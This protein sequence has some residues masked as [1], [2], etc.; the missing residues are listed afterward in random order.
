MNN[1][2]TYSGKVTI[3]IKNTKITTHNKGTVNLGKAIVKALAGYS[4]QSEIPCLLDFQQYV[5]NEWATLL[6]KKTPFTG[7]TYQ[8]FT[9]EESKKSDGCIGKLI[10]HTSIL[11]ENKNSSG[12]ISNPCR[13]CMY[14]SNTDN[15]PNPNSSLGLLA[16]VDN[17]NDTNIDYTNTEDNNITTI[18]GIYNK[19]E[20]GTQ[21][22][23]EWELSFYNK[24]EETNNGK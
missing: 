1:S 12:E 22:L 19:I 4:I 18:S 6:N 8:E 17:I 15:N 10:L 7:I 21:A 23:I 2:L 16:Y 24:I 14:N 11:Y 3:K 9:E 20:T 13:I 5:N